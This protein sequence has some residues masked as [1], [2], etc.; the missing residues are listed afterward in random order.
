V[1]VVELRAIFDNMPR[2]YDH[3]FNAVKFKEELEQHGHGLGGD[4]PGWMFEGVHIYPNTDDDATIGSGLRLKQACNTARF[5]G[6]K[7]ANRVS[8][9][10]ITHVVVENDRSRTKELRATFA[11]RKRQPRFVTIEWIEES[12]KERTLLDEERYAPR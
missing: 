9:K 8:D 7:I 6:A 10:D 12:W 2:K 4:L 5:A 3:T 1:T 11:T